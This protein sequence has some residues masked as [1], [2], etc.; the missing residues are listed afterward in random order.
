MIIDNLYTDSN[1]S[2]L[3]PFHTTL[4]TYVNAQKYDDDNLIFHDT[5]EAFSAQGKIEKMLKLS[6]IVELYGGFGG[7]IRV[8]DVPVYALM[9][10]TFFDNA[11]STVPSGFMYDTYVDD[12]EATQN[13]TWSKWVEIANRTPTYSVDDS[14][15]IFQLTDGSNLM[16]DAY[17]TLLHST[18]N[19]FDL[20]T[21]SPTY[22]QVNSGADVKLYTEP[23]I[24]EILNTSEWQE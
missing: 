4:V 14:K 18:Y 7:A 17:I 1:Y 20:N 3:I 11:S 24:K 10:K 2:V 8:L 16:N 13:T 23:Q 9:E 5:N 19:I 15:V 12:S 6:S 22:K 21:S